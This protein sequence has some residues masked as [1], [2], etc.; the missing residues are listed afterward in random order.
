MAAANQILDLVNRSL[1]GSSPI[2]REETNHL[3]NTNSDRKL[4][5]QTLTDWLVIGRAA[6]NKVVPFRVAGTCLETNL[7]HW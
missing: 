1:S 6:A 2:Q 3:I 7:Y 4:G 5:L